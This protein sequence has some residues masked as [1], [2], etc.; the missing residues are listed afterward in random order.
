MKRENLAKTGLADRTALYT[1]VALKCL[2]EAASGV[3]ADLT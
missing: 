1:E 2:N 3:V